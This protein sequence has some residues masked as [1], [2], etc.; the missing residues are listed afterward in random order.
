MPLSLHDQESVD[1]TLDYSTN[2]GVGQKIVK[3]EKGDNAI[4]ILTPAYNAGYVH[5]YRNEQGQRRR[6]VCAGG[7]EGEGWSPEECLLC[8]LAAGKFAEARET[9]DKIESAGIKEAARDVKGKFEATLIVAKGEMR[10]IRKK[11]KGKVKDIA[12]PVF[13]TDEMEIGLVNLTARQYEAY[14]DLLQNEKYPYMKS[15][16]DRT[17]RPIIFNKKKRGNDSF[18]S[19]VCRP[20][21]KNPQDKPDEILEAY[22]EGDFDVDAPYEI[23]MEKIEEAVDALTDDDGEDED[24]VELEDSEFYEDEDDEEDD[25]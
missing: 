25:D 23:D 21:T 3:I 6:V 18:E 9:S 20:A 13:D 8:E 11:V 19:L 7:L 17:N 14:C 24:D 12:V 5:W 10:I 2:K 22:D 15:P 4:W 16:K 1:S